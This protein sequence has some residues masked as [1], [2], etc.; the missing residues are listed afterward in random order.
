MP[1]FLIESL[2]IAASVIVT[3]SLIYSLFAL[4]QVAKIKH[5]EAPASKQPHVTLL[6]PVCGL[7]AGLYENLASFCRQDYPVFQVLFGIKDHDDPAIPVIKQIIEQHPDVDIELVINDSTSGTNRKICNLINMSEKI[8]HE[9]IVIS[10]SDMY[11]GPDYL[12]NVVAPFDDAEVGAV[13][14]LYKGEPADDKIAS[15]LGSAYINEWFIPSVLISSSLQKIKFCFGAT[16]AVRNN[17]LEKIGGFEQIA[18][19]LADD[20]MLGKLVNDLGYKVVLSPYLVKDIVDEE[21]VKSLFLHELRWGRTIR[22]VQPF[23]YLFSFLTHTFALTL[24]FLLIS[25][26]ATGLAAVITALIVRLW[27][28]RTACKTLGINMPA[29]YLLVPVRD[30]MSF[31]VW[32]C[33]FLGRNVNWRNHNFSIQANGQLAVKES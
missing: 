1:A 28:H 13:T 6:K 26:N 29:N 31:A 16:M 4:Y 5:P 2:N 14:C 25:P 30:L 20:Y 22:S 27:T 9:I 21:N 8:K 33:S 23:G 7:D 32:A 11:V 19:T 18:S 3:F 15:Q 17:L 12:A 10:D 24:L